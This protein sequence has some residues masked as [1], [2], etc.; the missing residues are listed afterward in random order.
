M[1]RGDLGRVMY[2]LLA[3]YLAGALWGL[4]R[5]DA[6]PAMRVALAALWPV[7]LLAFAVTIT[8]LC[9][10]VPVAFPRF[11]LVVAVAALFWWVVVG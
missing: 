4:V 7:G 10:A 5:V 3:V 8:V 6:R 9:A 11:G 2:L 1:Y